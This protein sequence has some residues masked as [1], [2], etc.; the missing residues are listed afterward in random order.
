M[1][2]SWPVTVM[3]TILK[4]RLLVRPCAPTDIQA[5]FS[6]RAACVVPSNKPS[7][8]WNRDIKHI[9]QAR[10]SFMNMS[11]YR[12]SARSHVQASVTGSLDAGMTAA[13]LS[14]MLQ[15]LGAAE[16]AK[17]LTKSFR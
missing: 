16:E 13:R 3:E 9:I 6:V 14:R 7:V 17:R 15:V 1:C 12:L 11:L 8:A 5:F 2:W 10:C 4:F